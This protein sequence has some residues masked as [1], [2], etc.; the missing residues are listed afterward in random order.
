MPV[1]ATSRHFEAAIL[2]GVAALAVRSA[3]QA[4][5]ISPSAVVWNAAL[6]LSTCCVIWQLCQCELLAALG[7]GQINMV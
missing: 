6:A 3:A 4:V 7:L 1:R 5:S 2:S